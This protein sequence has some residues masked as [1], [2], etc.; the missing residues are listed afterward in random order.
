MQNKSILILTSGYTGYYVIE[1]IVES[2]LKINP[3]IGSTKP[4]NINKNKANIFDFEK[5][6]QIYDIPNTTYDNSSNILPDVDII[7]C[8]DWKKDYFKDLKPNSIILHCH[9]SLLPKYRGYGAISEQFTRGVVFSGLSIYIDNGIIDSGD[10]VYQESIKIENYH[11]PIDFIKNCSNSIFNFI[12]NM[13]EYIAK[14]PTPQNNSKAFYLPKLRKSN[15]IIDFNAS[16]YFIYNFIRAFQEPYSYVSFFYQDREYLIKEASIESWSGL[17]G[18]PGEIIEIN[19]Y[20]IIVACGEG[21][22]LIKEIVY[23]NKIIY[24]DSLNLNIGVILH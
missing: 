7:I 22:I 23:N 19:N 3:F 20:G 4:V 16:A 18:Q 10:I 6:F 15:R 21:T 5:Q 13:D 9:P 14:D 12:K 24:P 11:K 8:I 17:D 1:R 2:K